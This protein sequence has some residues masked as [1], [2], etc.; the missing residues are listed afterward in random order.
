MKRK[1]NKNSP[2]DKNGAMIERKEEE[3]LFE[4]A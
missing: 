1:E 2:N 4:L 3:R